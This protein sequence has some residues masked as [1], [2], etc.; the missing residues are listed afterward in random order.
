MELIIILI[1]FVIFLDLP[2]FSSPKVKK[3][4][5]LS[6]LIKLAIVDLMEDAMSR[7]FS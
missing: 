2:S 6:V 7:V 4:R 3:H 1:I 5:F